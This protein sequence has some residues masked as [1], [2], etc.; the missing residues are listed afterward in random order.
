MN[1]TNLLYNYRIAFCEKTSIGECVFS[2]KPLLFL[3]NLPFSTTDEGLQDL[4][5]KRWLEDW[6][7]YILANNFY[8][9]WSEPRSC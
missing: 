6:K 7:D 8:L 5:S 2:H 1:G 3:R 9:Y 4:E